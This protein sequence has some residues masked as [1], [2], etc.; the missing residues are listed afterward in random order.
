M[1]GAVWFLNEWYCFYDDWAQSST[2]CF[3]RAWNRLVPSIRLWRF[4]TVI[5]DNQIIAAY[6]AVFTTMIMRNFILKPTDKNPGWKAPALI[7]F[8]GNAGVVSLAAALQYHWLCKWKN[9]SAQELDF[10]Y[11]FRGH[12]ATFGGSGFDATFS[13]QKF[14][15]QDPVLPALKGKDYEI[16]NELAK[17]GVKESGYPFWKKLEKNP[18]V[19][20]QLQIWENR[21]NSSEVILNFPEYREI[22]YDIINQ[23]RMADL[24]KP[25][26]N[27]PRWR[28][29]TLTFKKVFRKNWECIKFLK[30]CTL[31]TWRLFFLC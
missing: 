5:L 30:Q 15:I 19:K 31:L 16:R 17:I 2:D 26:G 1:S 25:W 10:I 6:G 14:K 20:D 29:Y 27:S 28:N 9:P 8:Y 22:Y 4:F 12:S 24:Q 13:H 7:G 23:Q 21:V 18:G 3:F 11:H